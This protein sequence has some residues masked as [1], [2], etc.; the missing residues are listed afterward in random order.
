MIRFDFWPALLGLPVL[1]IV[2]GI[3]A[4][5]A[6]KVS[7]TFTGPFLATTPVQSTGCFS[8]FLRWGGLTLLFLAL[9]RPQSGFERL[10]EAGEG[11]DIVITLDVSTSMLA[12]DY[13]PSRLGAARKAALDF[14]EG[15][16]NDR[17]GLVLYAN[18]PISICPPTFDHETL[19]RFVR[20]AELGTLEDGTAIGAGLAVAARGLDYSQSERRVIILI[21]D[22]VETS[23]RVNPITVAE[24]VH[25]IH[26]DSLRVYTVAIGTS[27]PA[28]YGVDRETLSR[29]AEI[30]GGRLFDVESGRDLEEVYAAIDELEASTL[31]SEGLFI[32]TDLYFGWLL[33]GFI[34]LLLDSVLRWRLL[35]VAGE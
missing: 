18:E 19:S 25:T 8:W 15:R 35:K 11:V 31:P 33:A 12:E 30:N 17:I 9:A 1:A 2:S 3:I 32:Y 27:S 6:R 21:S 28:A 29:I 13:N 10:P 34:M 14:I 5:R 26:G 4:G 22:G 20:R 23:G 7:E 24:A 16:P